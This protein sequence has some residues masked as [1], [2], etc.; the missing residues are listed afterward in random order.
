MSAPPLQEVLD[1][2]SERNAMLSVTLG[3]IS[4]ASRLQ[5]LLDRHAPSP[6]IPAV[7]QEDDHLTLLVLGL[8]ALRSRLA[9]LLEQA[10]PGPPAARSVA[11]ELRLRDLLR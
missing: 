10:P 3:L 8:I 11:G 1:G 5:F 7:P 6:A 4:A 9:A 2:M